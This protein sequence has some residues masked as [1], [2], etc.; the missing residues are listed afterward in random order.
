PE[1][2]L[3]IH[4]TSRYGAHFFLPLKA[5]AL[6]PP[7]DG[8]AVM[9]PGLA[10]EA[11]SRSSTAGYDVFLHPSPLG[12]DGESPLALPDDQAVIAALDR[13]IAKI[14]LRPHQPLSEAYGLLDTWF[15]SHYSYRVGVALRPGADPIVRFL[16]EA[17]QGHCELFATSGVLLL[18][19][20]GIPAR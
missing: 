7:G 9:E 1:P 8:I 19:R 15:A 17:Q 4:P 12:G 10:V 20:I 18:R 14:G 13:T 2:D 6:E 5:A 11:R 16:D 3:S